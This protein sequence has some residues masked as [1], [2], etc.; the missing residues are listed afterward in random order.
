V[1]APSPDA[2][3]AVSQK[4][5]PLP[6]VALTR[7]IDSFVPADQ[8]EKLTMIAAA[9]GA[10]DPAFRAPKRAPRSECRLRHEFDVRQG[11]CRRAA[12]E[13]ACPLGIISR[14]YAATAPKS[15]PACQQSIK[16]YPVVSQPGGNLW[17]GRHRLF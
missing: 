9:A 14:R 7:T 11:A 3:L 17:A 6:Q 5:A 4:L 16:A 2:A 10:V 13:C 8:D 1:L 12:P 15:N